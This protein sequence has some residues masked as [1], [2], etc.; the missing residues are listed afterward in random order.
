MYDRWLEILVYVVKLNLS[1]WLIKHQAMKTYRWLEV[2]LHN[3]WPRH[4][5]EVSGRL[6][7]PAALPPGKE[8][9]V[10]TRL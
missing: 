3:F 6:H 9:P 2:S 8:A 7:V 5:M 1:L 4:E 10:P